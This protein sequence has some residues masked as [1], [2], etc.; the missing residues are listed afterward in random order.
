MTEQS[1]GKA[2]KQGKDLPRR[3]EVVKSFFLEGSKVFKKPKAGSRAI[4]GILISGAW[5]DPPQ[6]GTG[7]VQEVRRHKEVDRRPHITRDRT[8]AVAVVPQRDNVGTQVISQVSKVHS[9]VAALPI[10]QA[11]PS[12]TGKITLCSSALLHT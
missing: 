12:G 9:M 6:Q 1:R 3:V 10:W 2:E 8:G 4:I 7:R 5:K 11:A